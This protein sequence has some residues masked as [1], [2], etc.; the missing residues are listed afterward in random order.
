MASTDEEQL[1]VSLEARINDF[2][3]NFA[4]ATQ[5]ANDNY[6]KIEDRGRSASDRMSS[7]IKAATSSMVDSF[8]SLEGST[9]SFGDAITAVVGGGIIAGGI[10]RIA[11]IADGLAKIGDRS[12]ELRLPVNMLQALGIAADEARLSQD[13]LNSALDKFTEVSKKSADDSKDFFKAL[14]NIGPGFEAAFKSAPTQQ[15][16]L[17]V[18]SNALHSTGDEVKRAQLALQAFGTDSERALAV[19]GSGSGGIESVTQKMHALGLEIDESAVRRAQEAKS[20]LS[21]L[22]KVIGDEL[23]SSLAG[24][25]PTFGSLLPYMEKLAGLARDV[26]AIFASSDSAK[27]VETLQNEIGTLQKQLADLEAMRARMA[28]NTPSNSDTLRDKLRSIIGPAL[29]VDLNESISDVDK[30]ITEIKARSS[31]VNSLI[32][33]KKNTQPKSAAPAFK[34]RPKLNDDKDDDGKTAF[35]GEIDSLNKHI[36][37]LKA[38]AAAIGLTDSAHQ[39]LRAELALLQAAQRDD[40][41]VTNEQIDAYTRLRAS[42][43]AQQ[44]LTAA[45]IKLNKEN[46]ESFTEVTKRVT[47][48]AK[49]LDDAKQHVQGVSDSLRFAGNELIDVF[50]QASKKGANFQTIMVGVLQAVEKQML[51]AAITGDGSFGK[52]FGMASTT[53][54]VGGLMGA[55]A[56]LFSGG[57]AEG[58]LI[59]GPGSGTSDSVVARVSNGEFVVRADATRRNL[60][61]LHAINSGVPAFADGGLV[62]RPSISSV[63]GNVTNHVSNVTVNATGGRPQDNQDLA[64]KVGRAMQDHART[65]IATEI[66]TQLR[67]GGLFAR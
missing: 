30:Q 42:M 55:F 60:P 34:P 49:N 35:D 58:G 3:S 12:E 48:A 62:G 13:K 19:L 57:H 20:E 52:L 16:R 38:D 54:G 47:E 66:R 23:S 4:K 51:Q 11:S 29:G 40:A 8:N 24:L 67:P 10:A 2:E 21:L 65:M 17:I 28:T 61:L 18:V 53:G 6:Q 39:G 59:S 14:S 22:A 63:A 1:V 31:T 36:A 32:D 27:P 25:I 7:D 5:T 37:A 44:A 9:K 26:V 43:S 64:D 45:G 33:Q 15:A 46:A 56:K 50:D 41:G